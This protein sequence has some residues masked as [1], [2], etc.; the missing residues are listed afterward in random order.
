MSEKCKTCANFRPF[1]TGDHPHGNCA[2]LPGLIGVRSFDYFAVPGN[3]GC[4][5][6]VTKTEKP[7]VMSVLVTYKLPGG[8]IMTDDCTI[9]SREEWEEVIEAVWKARKV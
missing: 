1:K 5:G 4:F 7:H 3:F 2:V 9:I 6:H 8:P